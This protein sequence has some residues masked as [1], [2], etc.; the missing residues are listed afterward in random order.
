MASQ[1]KIRV[2]NSGNRDFTLQPAPGKKK[3]RLLPSGRAIDIEEPYA[4]RLL[5]D[6]P[7]DLIEFDSLVTGS[8]K[9]LHKENA[10]LE[11]ENETL[12]DSIS[13]GEKAFWDLAV[14][15]EKLS[16]EITKLKAAGTKKK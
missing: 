5:A 13:A 11:D 15:N 12:N 7:K 4:K 9:N 3:N 6:Y 16:A 8:K 10:K 1:E 14:E 2:H